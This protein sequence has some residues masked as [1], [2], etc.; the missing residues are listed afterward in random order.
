MAFELFVNGTLM[1]G[2]KLHPN[3][4]ASQFLG[5]FH[6]APYYRVHTIGD[7]H[8]GM[9]R[10]EA[11]EVGGVAIAGELYMVEDEVWQQIEAG[12]PPNLYRGK[13]E[14]E[15]GREVYGILFPRELAQLYLDI[16]EY[17]GWRGYMAQHS[18]A[19]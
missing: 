5:E 3:M 12:E 1:H 9:Y 17:G 13:V 14:L 19:S 15:D 8:P 2:L 11:D 18:E 7:I 16:S 10:L 4:G 6:T